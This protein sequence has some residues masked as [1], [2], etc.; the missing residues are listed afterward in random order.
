MT[1]HACPA[2]GA[3]FDSKTSLGSHIVSHGGLDDTRPAIDGVA[4]CPHC[5]TQATWRVVTQDWR[6]RGCGAGIEH[7]DI[8]DRP[9]LAHSGGAETNGAEVLERLSPA[10]F[11]RQ[12]LDGGGDA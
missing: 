5:D 6:C 11:E 3:T 12:V 7:E 8:F 2:C 9:S 10:E 1:D 4:A